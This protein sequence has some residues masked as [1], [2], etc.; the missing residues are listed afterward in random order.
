MVAS[1]SNGDNHQRNMQHEVRDMISTLTNRLMALGRSTARSEAKSQE[2]GDA[3]DHGLRVVTL[4]GDNKGASMKADMEELMDT[5]GGV[6]DD[7]SGMCTHANS[8]F[9]AVNNSIV[10]GGSCSAE[11]PGVHLSMGSLPHPD[12]LLPILILLLPLTP[13]TSSTPNYDAEELLRSANEDKEWLVSVRRRIHEHPE[14]RFQE[15]NTSALIRAQLDRLGV[16]YSF[17]Y[18]GTGVVAQVGSGESPVIALRADM[19]ALPLQEL[20]DWKH[21]SKNDGVMHA[22]GHDAHVAMLLGAAKLLNQRQ[23]KLK[24]TVRLIFQP[25]EEGGAGASHMIKDGVLDGVEAIFGMH[26]AYQVPT[27]S[28]ESHPG[29]TQAAVCFFEA[30]IEGKA[31]EAAKPHLNVDP[32]VAASFAILSMQQLISREDDPL[33]SQVLS[34]TYVKG[35]SSF[36]ETPPFVEFGGTLRSITTEG[37]HRLQRRVKE[38]VEGQAAVHQCKALV[39]MLE[40]DFP[41]YPAVV[42]DAGLHDHVQQVG[43]L[44]LGRDKVKM[45][46]KIMAGED[47]AFYQQLIPG[48]IF[49]TGIKNESAGSVYPAHSPYFFIDEDVLPI[50]A[51]LHTAIAE[52][53]LNQHSS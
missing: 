11:D 22:C 28:I 43:A 37:L 17:P 26:V 10:L 5:H 34:V 7:D 24:G 45:G 46:K 20:M 4:A 36:D 47:F 18:A 9:Q 1:G 33:H 14:L 12:L 29:P 30:K 13:L 6:Y 44:L 21:K 19:D 16:P 15:H 48:I 23:S 39:N 38:V 35:G 8:N 53:Y 3:A 27:G 49:A 41:F 25:A 42:N 52:L 50:G 32:L 40:E 2:A 31:G 51:A